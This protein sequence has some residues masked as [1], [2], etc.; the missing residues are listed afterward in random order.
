MTPS[1][2]TPLLLNHFGENGLTTKWF[3]L[4]GSFKYVPPRYYSPCAT[5]LQ[6]PKFIPISYSKASLSLVKN[7]P[8]NLWSMMLKVLNWPPIMSPSDHFMAAYVVVVVRFQFLFFFLAQVATKIVHVLLY[9]SMEYWTLYVI[10]GVSFVVGI[11][12]H[13]YSLQHQETTVRISILVRL[14][15]NRYLEILL[16]TRSCRRQ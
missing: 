8:R 14:S 10:F 3:M 2:L 13:V 4:V 7:R 12:Y 1:N 15:P 9:L 16:N 5:D 11:D 6:R